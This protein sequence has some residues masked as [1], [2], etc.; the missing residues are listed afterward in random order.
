[1]VC[2]TARVEIVRRAVVVEVVGFGSVGRGRVGPVVRVE[3]LRGWDVGGIVRLG[4]FARA[5]VG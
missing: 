3:G 5:G 1:M 2:R 4:G